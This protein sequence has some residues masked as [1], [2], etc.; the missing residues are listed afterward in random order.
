M[1]FQLERVML[2]YLSGDFI[3]LGHVF[4]DNSIC[5]KATISDQEFDMLQEFEI[6]DF[7]S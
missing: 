3:N 2:T 1:T 5:V 7:R 6:P 4:F